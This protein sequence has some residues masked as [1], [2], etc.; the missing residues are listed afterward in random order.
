MIGPQPKE[1]SDA[2]YPPPLVL[3]LYPSETI[4]MDKEPGQ[5][6][7][8]P[9]VALLDEMRETDDAA[10]YV[11]RNHAFHLSLYRLAGR[12]RLVTMIEELRTASLAYNHLY[13]ASDV[14]GAAPRL[15]AEHRAILSACQANDPSRAVAAV[16]HHMQQTIVHVQGMLE[17]RGEDPKG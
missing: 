11:A 5:R 7:A 3:A 2:A 10:R 15:D 13:A 4:R 9:L 16:R 17:R 14:P 6:D 8:P 12:S 1:V